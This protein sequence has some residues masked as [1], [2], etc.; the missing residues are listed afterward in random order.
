[1]HYRMKKNGRQEK[2]DDENNFFAIFPNINN[3][4][5]NNIRLFE[6]SDSFS[7]NDQWQ[8]KEETGYAV[9]GG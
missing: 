7:P 1:M 6:Y 2:N 9:A 5:K 4:F 3:R 8:K